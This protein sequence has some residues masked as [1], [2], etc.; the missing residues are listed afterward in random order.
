M[1]DIHTL[2]LLWE[3]LYGES[4][5]FMSYGYLLYPG[6][7]R[8]SA[9][10]ILR[11]DTALCGFLSASMIRAGVSAR[12]RSSRTSYRRIVLDGGATM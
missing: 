10:A 9:A 3:R 5:G 7:G 12:A 2:G 11:P 8:C 1:R 6:S 4:R